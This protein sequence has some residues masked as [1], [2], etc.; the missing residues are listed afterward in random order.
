MEAEKVIYRGKYYWG[1]K[2]CPE[3][4]K[5]AF[6]KAVGFKCEDCGLRED[7]DNTLEIH[8]PKRKAD[9]GLYMCVPKNHPLS[10]A[11]VLCEKDHKKYNYSPKVGS[12]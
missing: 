6:K 3:W 9:G 4:L 2:V 8:R 1:Y 5:Q 10:N 7:E 11:K 12:Y